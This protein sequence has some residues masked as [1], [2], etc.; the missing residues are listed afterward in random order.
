M[1][2]HHRLQTNRS[3]D[4]STINKTKKITLN[5][6]TTNNS[7]TVRSNITMQTKC[8][9]NHPPHNKI[10]TEKTQ[11]L[12]KP[13]KFWAHY[14]IIIGSKRRE[15]HLCETLE[16]SFSF[17]VRMSCP[18]WGPWCWFKMET[19]TKTDTKN[20][21]SQKNGMPNCGWNENG[22]RPEMKCALNAVQFGLALIPTIRPLH[23]Y[24]IY[25]L[26]DASLLS[27][28][29]LSSGSSCPLANPLV[30]FGLYSSRLK[31]LFY[32]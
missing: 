22:T 31:W 15:I 27:G 16:Y 29:L 28:P 3:R 25:G 11:N 26:R 10:R 9:K 6:V 4:K 23:E 8:S 14:A 7:L 19:K 32:P 13:W 20:Q 30:S 18:P 17:E 21:A 12:T 2:I 1:Q 5:F 24:W